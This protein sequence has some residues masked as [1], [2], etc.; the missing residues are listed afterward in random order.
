MPE[1]KASNEVRVHRHLEQLAAPPAEL[2]EEVVGV[3]PAL[4]L[5]RLAD[6]LGL[7]P[8]QDRRDVL[9]GRL[10]VLDANLRHITRTRCKY[11]K[12]HSKSA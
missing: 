10:Q 1:H 3:A 2:L 8:L 9:V 7:D 11:T 5:V 6:V 12:C 4:D